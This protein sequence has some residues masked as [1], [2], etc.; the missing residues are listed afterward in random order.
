MSWSIFDGGKRSEVEHTDDVRAAHC[1]KC[2]YVP[3]HKQH[4]QQSDFNSEY[5]RK[6]RN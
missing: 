4:A 6:P 1:T 3:E 5:V 2:K